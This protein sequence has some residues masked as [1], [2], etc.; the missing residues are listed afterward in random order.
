MV[1]KRLD[2]AY[3]PGS[4]SGAWRR[5]RINQ[6]EE[7]VIG[8]YTLDCMNFDALLFGCYEADRL[9]V[10]W[11]NAQRLHTVVEG[12]IVPTV[13][14]PGDRGVPFRQPPGGQKR[15][16]GAGFYREQDE[17]VPLAATGSGRAVRV[18][19]M[20]A[21]G[22]RQELADSGCG[23]RDFHPARLLGNV[24]PHELVILFSELA[25]VA[26]SPNSCARWKTPT[27]APNTRQAPSTTVSRDA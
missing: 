16:L 5:M 22:I 19:G 20:D 11:T 1:A 21:N 10:R 25:A 12:P 2:S 13:P 15:T 6:A 26:L 3:E 24:E 17:G 4:R 14:R 23:D 27:A 7:F 9:L 8:G 18:C